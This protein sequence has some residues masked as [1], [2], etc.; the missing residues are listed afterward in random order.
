MPTTPALG[1][2]IHHPRR[3]HAYLDHPLGEKFNGGG[4]VRRHENI[5]NALRWFEFWFSVTSREAWVLHCPWI[6]YV[7]A[8]DEEI[9][10]PRVMAAQWAIADRCHVVLACGSIS[11]H[12]AIGRDRALRRGQPWVDTTE[13]G[14]YPPA[15]RDGTDWIVWLTQR[16]TF[17]ITI[18]HDA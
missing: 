15:D 9:H 8:V 14:A 6:V 3:V 5:A 13:L 2:Q 17:P 16:S 11:P 4:F 18:D 1:S 10:R 7:M 12:M